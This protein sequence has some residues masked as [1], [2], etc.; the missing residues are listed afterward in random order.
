MSEGKNERWSV[1]YVKVYKHLSYLFTLSQE[2]MKERDRKKEREREI[3][4]ERKKERKKRK[5]STREYYK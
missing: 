5:E 1:W 2:R 4:R 3:E